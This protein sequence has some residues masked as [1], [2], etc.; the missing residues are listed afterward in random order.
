MK[1]LTS[2]VLIFLLLAAA[3][4]R[5]HSAQNPTG[6][7]RPSAP[8]EQP[9]RKK[10]GAECVVDLK[11][12]YDV[13]GS[14]V[15]KML[16]DFRIFVAGDCTMP[17]GT[18]SEHWIAYGTYDVRTGD[19]QYIGDLTYLATVESGGLVDGT[20][21]LA[22]QLSMKLNVKGNFKNGFMSYSGM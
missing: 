20:L 11:Q 8:P 17:P 7:F 4:G 14:L 12:A 10:V 21:T 13:A 3:F 1:R 9:T 19:T 16:I 5:A 6:T 18:F 2:R 15:G 22:G